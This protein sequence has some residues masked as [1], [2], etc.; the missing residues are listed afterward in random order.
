MFKF[1]FRI[2]M[3]R[4]CCISYSETKARSFSATFTS[5]EG[6]APTCGHLVSR[7]RRKG[8]QAPSTKGCTG[9]GAFGPEKRFKVKSFNRSTPVAG[10]ANVGVFGNGA[11]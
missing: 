5:N 4:H 3:A 2:E 6:N 7:Q 10:V 11:I 1:S 9:Q 8:T